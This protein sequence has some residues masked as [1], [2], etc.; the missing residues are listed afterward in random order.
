MPLS[1][2]MGGLSTTVKHPNILPLKNRFVLWIGSQLISQLR[3]RKGIIETVIQIE[4]DVIVRRQIS[5]PAYN[6]LQCMK[7]LT[8]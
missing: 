2:R 4:N 8:A 5:T 6:P 3:G 1:F 7:P